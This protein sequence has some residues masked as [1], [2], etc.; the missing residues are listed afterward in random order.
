MMES[1]RAKILLVEDN[2]GD[3]E[4]VR[5]AFEMG[6]LSSALHVAHDGMEAL[7]YMYGRGAYSIATVPDLIL[8]DLNMPRM[9]GK[10]FLTVVKRNEML[11]LIPVIIFSSSHAPMDIKEAYQHYANCYVMKPFCL[12]KYIEVAKQLE[13][14]WI[15]LSQPPSPPQSGHY[16]P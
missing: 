1:R 2:E 5:L 11:K 12:E 10:E 3:I 13:N 4:L 15:T 8:L 16:P 7:D 9:G 6:N 14:F